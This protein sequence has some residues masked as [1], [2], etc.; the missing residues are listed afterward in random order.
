VTCLFGIAE[1][2]TFMTAIPK[3][4]LKVELH[5]GGAESVGEMMAV[6]ACGNGEAL[7]RATLAARIAKAYCMLGNATCKKMWC[8]EYEYR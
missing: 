5:P 1:V 4:P 3:L 7:T 6:T 2:L 8:T